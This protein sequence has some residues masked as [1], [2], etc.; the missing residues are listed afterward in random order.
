MLDWKP[1]LKGKTYCSPACGGGCT[2]RQYERMANTGE[3]ICLKLG[4]GWGF[5]L[6]EN[7]GWYVTVFSPC[8]H[9]I[10]TKQGEDFEA[11]LTAGEERFCVKH[12]NVKTAVGDVVYKFNQH[13]HKLMKI[14]KDLPCGRS[15]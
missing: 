9:I 13:I 5:K 4:E 12:A 7:L 6:H 1:V 15:K 11:T 10:V 3:D 14:A 8:N 2:K